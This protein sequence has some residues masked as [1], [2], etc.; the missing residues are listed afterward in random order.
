MASGPKQATRLGGE[1]PR[2]GPKLEP[3][4][5]AQEGEP[6]EVRLSD[7][8]QAALYYQRK[9]RRLGMPDPEE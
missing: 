7:E 8:Q 2:P 6:G 9:R 3:L 1:Y 5:P 4:K